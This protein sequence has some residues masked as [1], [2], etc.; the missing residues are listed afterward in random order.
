V[1][2]EELNE[3]LGWD[4]PKKDYETVGGLMLSAMGRIPRPG[5]HVVVGGYELSVVDADERRILKVKVRVRQAGTRALSP[6]G[7]RP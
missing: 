5:E 6:E 4:L 1:G 3:T 2:L 7:K